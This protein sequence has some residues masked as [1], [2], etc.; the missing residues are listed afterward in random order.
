MS[1]PSPVP[2][3]SRVLIAETDPGAA[4]ALHFF[5]QLRGYEVQQ[6]ESGE[7]AISTFCTFEPHAVLLPAMLSDMPAA[8]VIRKLSEFP[9]YRSSLTII[10]LEDPHEEAMEALHTSI[11]RHSVRRGD[12]AE[13][14]RVLKLAP[15]PRKR[16]RRASPRHAGGAA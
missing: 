14:H 13:I 9:H 1:H 11:E 7:A 4:Q 2:S 16:V 12:H 15:L 8:D 10:I 3:I 6:V 5:L